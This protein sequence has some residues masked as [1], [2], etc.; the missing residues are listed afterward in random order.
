[1][2][3][4]LNAISLWIFSKPPISQPLAEWKQTGEATQ[5]RA[6]RARN[7]CGGRRRLNSCCCDGLHVSMRCCPASWTDVKLVE[8]ARAPLLSMGSDSNR[9][10]E[11]AAK[12]KCSRIAS[13]CTSEVS[14]LQKDRNNIHLSFW[15]AQSWEIHEE[16]QEQKVALFL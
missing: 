13:V 9:P 10:G 3:V 15:I 4:L 14:K 16:Q 8:R 6:K 5:T 1:M 11:H 12:I 2:G 7:P